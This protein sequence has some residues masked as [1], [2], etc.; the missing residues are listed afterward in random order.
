MIVQ[1][2]TLVFLSGISSCHILQFLYS[3]NDRIVLLFYYAEPL[4]HSSS[5]LTACLMQPSIYIDVK[6]TKH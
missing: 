4:G 1:G 6:D 3:L 2:Y 5:V